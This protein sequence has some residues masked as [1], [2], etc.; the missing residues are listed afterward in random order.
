MCGT[1]GCDGTEEMCGPPLDVAPGGRTHATAPLPSDRLRPLQEIVDLFDPNVTLTGFVGRH[2][3]GGACTSD[4]R[5]SIRHRHTVMAR[6]AGFV[7]SAR[8]IARTAELMRG[9]ATDLYFT[10]VVAP[11]VALADA[12]RA[13]LGHVDTPAWTGDSARAGF[14][15]EARHWD[16]TVASAIDHLVR[17][18][19]GTTVLTFLRSSSSTSAAQDVQVLMELSD[20]LADAIRAIRDY[21]AVGQPGART[22]ASRLRDASEDPSTLIGRLC[23]TF[24]GSFAPLVAEA[25]RSEAERGGAERSEGAEGAESE[26]GGLGAV[27]EGA[28][29]ALRGPKMLLELATTFAVEEL[30]HGHDKAGFAS[31]YR[32]SRNRLA[33]MLPLG[34]HAREE[35]HEALVHGQTRTAEHILEEHTLTP[36]RTTLSAL[37]AVLEFGAAMNEVVEHPTLERVVHLTGTMVEAAHTSAE[38]LVQ[39][40]RSVTCEESL[41][42]LARVLEATSGVVV[43][44]GAVVGIVTGVIQLAEALE[45]HD[46][47]GVVDAIAGITVSWLMLIGLAEVP[48][49]NVA[50]GFP[51]GWS[52]ATTRTT[53]MERLLRRH[54]AVL[55]A[56]RPTLHTAPVRRTADLPPL[57]DA[58]HLEHAVAELERAMN[59]T[60]FFNINVSLFAHRGEV[61]VADLRNAYVATVR[62]FGVESADANA[63]VVTA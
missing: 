7:R 60:T 23:A 53:A 57:C 29:H 25:D 27:A 56:P 18:D 6:T 58:L 8:V 62:S 36:Y 31:A 11:P 9:I 52:S 46:G 43:V 59:D 61:P 39:V 44:V 10:G 2:P 38:A 37:V 1:D 50:V 47:M 54:L 30:V 12:S 48:G 32:V 26:E 14:P 51:W 41:A 45:H 21:N 24:M 4:I 63:V 34:H 20:V 5:T 16:A 17:T 3:G 42:G 55:K 13:L 22:A 28:V 40:L 49:V 35:L 33:S 19:L 15:N